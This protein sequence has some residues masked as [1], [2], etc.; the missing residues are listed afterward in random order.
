MKGWIVKNSSCGLY[1]L[2]SQT[3]T[4]NA[5]T[6]KKGR[7]GLLRQT[8]EGHH[9]ESLYDCWGGIQ[10][11]SSEIPVVR[12]LIIGK[13]LLMLRM[14]IVGLERSISG[15]KHLLSQ[16]FW[17]RFLVSTWQFTGICNFQ[18]LFSP[19]FS[20]LCRYQA[21]AWSTDT[22]AGKTLRHIK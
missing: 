17:F 3:G 18:V 8:K 2:E 19:M 5:F 16:R 4:Y 14:F 12:P 22:H 7:Y 11:K 15:W 1:H 9:E 10:E 20:V 6:S 21:C 13:P